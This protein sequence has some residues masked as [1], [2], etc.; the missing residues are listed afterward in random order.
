MKTWPL[1]IFAVALALCVV[2]CGSDD[3]GVAGADDRFLCAASNGGLNLCTNH[4][5]NPTAEQLDQLGNQMFCRFEPCS[6][7]RPEV[8]GENQGMQGCWPVRALGYCEVPGGTI[9]GFEQI[10]LTRIQH[11]FYGA[12]ALRGV[13]ILYSR[14]ELV[15]NCA[16]LS[17][18]WSDQYTPP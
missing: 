5:G 17:G 4:Y 12:T 15:Q 1:A 2:A 16:N 6:E 8:C 13:V 10:A 7:Q 18:A 11:V 9:M 3:D 14:E